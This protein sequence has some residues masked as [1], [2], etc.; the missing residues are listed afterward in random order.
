[1]I[2]CLNLVTVTPSIKLRPSGQS[3]S[4]SISVPC[5]YC[6]ECLQAKRREYEVRF[7][8]EFKQLELNGAIAIMLLLSYNQEH[9]AHI[10]TSHYVAPTAVEFADEFVSFDN[11]YLKT[12]KNRLRSKCYKRWKCRVYRFFIAPEFGENGVHNPHYHAIF[13]LKK[14]VDVN[15]FYD[16]VRSIWSDSMHVGFVF[17]NY[18]EHR[19]NDGSKTRMYYKKDKITKRIVEQ[20]I[21]V[22]SNGGAAMY[23]AKYVTKQFLLQGCAKFIDW[24]RNQSKDVRKKLNRFIPRYTFSKSF[25]MQCVEFENLSDVYTLYRALKFGIKPPYFHDYIAVPKF[26][27]RK[28]F[29]DNVRLGDV[30]RETGLPLYTAVPSS[31]AVDFVSKFNLP[32]YHSILPLAF[33]FLSCHNYDLDAVTLTKC[34]LMY[35]RVTCGE[36]VDERYT[37]FVT[38]KLHPFDDIDIIVRD[39]DLVVTCDV[40]RTPFTKYDDII[41]DFLKWLDDLCH[42]QMADSVNKAKYFYKTRNIFCD[43]EY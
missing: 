11:E 35:R 7:A 39:G 22:R 33:Q 29:Y 31:L 25:G 9:V 21:E 27:L 32:S 18:K 3:F 36:S 24:Y 16:I 14:G 38:S 34:F 6:D 1:M 37:D 15:E 19:N 13:F 23:C 30:S 10:S 26:V 20:K 17:P 5:G 41:G 28:L 40:Y 8:Y 43:S 2:M 42:T 12:F 4:D